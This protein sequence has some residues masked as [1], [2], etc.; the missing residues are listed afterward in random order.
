MINV[1]YSNLYPPSIVLGLELR[2]SGR[3]GSALKC[4]AISSTQKSFLLLLFLETGFLCSLAGPGWSQTQRS[5]CLCL[6]SAGI[7]GMWYHIWLL[8]LFYFFSSLQ[9]PRLALNIAEDDLDLL[10]LL[11]LPPKCRDFSFLSEVG[12][13]GRCWGLNPEP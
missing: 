12:W 5:A 9:Y 11:H 8:I 7:K 10:I 4:R 13:G 3:A 2:T 6:Q 1:F